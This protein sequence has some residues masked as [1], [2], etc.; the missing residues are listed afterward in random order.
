M[1]GYQISRAGATPEEVLRPMSSLSR[2]LLS[3]C[4]YSKGTDGGAMASASLAQRTP[5]ALDNSTG[6]RRLKADAA[7]YDGF[8]GIVASLM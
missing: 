6:R 1:R 4:G 5:T 3:A 7:S 8:T 2:L